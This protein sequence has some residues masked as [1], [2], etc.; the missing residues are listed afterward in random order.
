[1]PNFR[2]LGRQD[3]FEDAALAAL[4]SGPEVPEDLASGLQP[5]ADVLAALRARPAG[6]ELAGEALAMAEFRERVGASHPARA[7]RPR[8]RPALL[9]S[10]M[11]AKVAVAAAAVAITIGGVATAAYAGALP[12]P[13]QSIAHDVIGAPAGHN[14]SSASRP[15]AHRPDG[16]LLCYAYAY[17]KAH[18]TA[19]QQA[20]IYKKLVKAAGG[21]SKVA[22]YCAAARRPHHFRPYGCMQPGPHP[23]WSPTPSASPSPSP[24]FTPLPRPTCTPMP[25]PSFTPRPHRHRH[26]RRF[27]KHFPHPSFSP[28]PQPSFTPGPRPSAPSPQG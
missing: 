4:L 23:T 14:H 25:H 17:A 22:A 27:G 8:R 5:V 9:T 13:A 1:M 18:G 21:A 12:G 28:K 26:H 19:A 11:S 24:S 15:S 16:H 6:D 2:W 20:A 10:L 7:T 3:A